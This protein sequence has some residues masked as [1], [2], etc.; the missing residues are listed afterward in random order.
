M[1]LLKFEFLERFNGVE[2]DWLVIGIF[3]YLRSA[4]GQPQEGM[5][6]SAKSFAH[7]IDKEVDN[8]P[9]GVVEAQDTGDLEGLID[10]GPGHVDITLLD[11]CRAR[12]YN[13]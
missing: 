5:D 2:Y 12:G 11:I 13:G 9:S 8:L 4:S 1:S 7:L 3:G 10:R 6:W